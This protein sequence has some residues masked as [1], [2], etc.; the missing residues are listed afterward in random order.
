[1]RESQ[2]LEIDALAELLDSPD[3]REAIGSYSEKRRP[4]FAGEQGGNSARSNNWAVEPPLPNLPP[5]CL[6]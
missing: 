3:L 6:S 5:G 1:M 4:Q 2:N